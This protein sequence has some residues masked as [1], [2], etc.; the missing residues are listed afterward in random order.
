MKILVCGSG[1]S[2]LYFSSKAKKIISVEHDKD[3]YKKVSDIISK[4]NIK[5]CEYCLIEPRKS[6]GAKILPYS[7]K[8]YIAKT[9]KHHHGLSFKD[10]VKKIDSFPDNSFDLI[11]V[12]GRSRAACLRHSIKKI[13]KD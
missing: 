4:K 9:F 8:T 6:L 10:Y 3:W 5:N 2:T 1:G 11:F 7:Q 13:K 12:D